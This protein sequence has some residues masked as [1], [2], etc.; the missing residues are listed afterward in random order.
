MVYEE[1]H[2]DQ[3]PGSTSVITNEDKYP[4]TGFTFKEYTAEQGWSMFGGSYDKYD[5]AKFYYTRNTYNV[6]Y[7]NNG[8]KEHEESYKYKADISGAGEAYTATTPPAGT[9][10]YVFDGWYADPVGDTKY[11][12]TGKTM[13]AN[14]ITVYAKWVAPTHIVT[15]Y[16]DAKKTT[17]LDTKNIPHGGSISPDQMPTMNVP[18]GSVFLGW[19]N[20]ADGKPFNFD[21]KIYDDYELYALVGSRDGYKVTYDANGGTGDVP[22]DPNKYAAGTKATVKGKTADM[23][24]P[25]DKEFFL[26]WATTSNATTAEYQ[27]GGTMPIDANNAVNGV[28]MLYAVWGD[29]PAT[30]TL[31]YNANFGETPAEKTHA[32]TDGTTDLPNNAEVTLYDKDTFTRDGYEL[33]GWAKTANATEADYDFGDKVI[34]DNLGATANILYAV[35]KQSTTTVTV[36]K[37]VEGPMG[38]RTRAF[39]FEYSLD[40]GTTW[41][42]LNEAGLKHN[43]SAMITGVAIGSTLLIREE[44]VTNYTVTAGSSVQDKTITVADDSNG[45][46]LITVPSVAAS[47]TITVTNTNTLVPD[48]GVIL[49]SLPYVL[50]LAVVAL[51]AAGVVIRRR[52]SREDD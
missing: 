12:F 52:R 43:E 38:D 51:G 47:E 9:T 42:N 49:D 35:W 18:E 5:G 14:N 48:T 40:N 37:V 25:A 17:L 44:K 39:E 1:H 24:P 10:G 46:T 33:I 19:V 4:I 26:G 45:F 21:T 29:K 8:V 30:T 36:K 50:I 28:I 7:M 20:L 22:S 34:V 15:V 11:E 3:S 31:T 2:K 6:V 32:L 13:P 16:D 23:T 27:P 41:Q